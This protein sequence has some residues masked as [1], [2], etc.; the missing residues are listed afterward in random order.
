M[1]HADMVIESVTTICKQFGATSVILFGSRATGN[2]VEKSDIDIAIQG[3]GLELN[4][5]EEKLEEIPS[6]LTINIVDL[7]TASQNLKK[8]IDSY[9]RL[10]YKA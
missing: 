2:S 4:F 6:L 10:L 8:D 3:N 7:S 9:G 1:N 5:I